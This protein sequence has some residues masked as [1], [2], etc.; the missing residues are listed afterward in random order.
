MNRSQRKTLITILAA[1]VVGLAIVATSYV[2]GKGREEKHLAQ[3]EPGSLTV[4]NYKKR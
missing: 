1:I 2:I 3:D 4:T